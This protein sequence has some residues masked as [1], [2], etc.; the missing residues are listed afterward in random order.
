MPAETPACRLQSN[1]EQEVKGLLCV[2]D[3]IMVHARFMFNAE[4]H[5]QW[6]YVVPAC[7]INMHMQLPEGSPC[8]QSLSCISY[9]ARML[10]RQ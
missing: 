4:L 5:Q 10:Y 2:H 7:G 1:L 9:A 3:A 6:L 8:Q